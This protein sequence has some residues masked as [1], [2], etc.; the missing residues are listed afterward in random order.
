MTLCSGESGAGKTENTKKVISYF[1][2]VAAA[3]KKA[4]EEDDSHKVGSVKERDRVVVNSVCCGVWNA[5]VSSADCADSF[6]SS[7]DY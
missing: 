3:P 4:G 5:I 1:A 6:P 2:N 7:A